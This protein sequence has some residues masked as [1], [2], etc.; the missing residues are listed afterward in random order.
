[1]QAPFAMTHRP[2]N[3]DAHIGH[4]FAIFMAS[5]GMLRPFGLGRR[6]PLALCLNHG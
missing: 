2:F 5:A 6:F 1:M 3:A 4:G